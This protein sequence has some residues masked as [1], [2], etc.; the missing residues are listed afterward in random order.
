SRQAVAPRVGTFVSARLVGRWAVP[1][2]AV[3]L[4]ILANT[5]AA[6]THLKRG[7]EAP[8]FALKDRDGADITTT[9]L[10]DHVVVLIFGEV[11]HEKTQQAW[12]AIRTVLDDDRLKD[13]GI[14]PVVITAQAGQ[15]E[16][17]KAFTGG[18]VT[19]RMARDPERQAFEAYRVVAMPSVVVIDREG[20]VVYAVAGLVPRYAD[21]VADSLMYACGKLSA[22]ALERSLHPVPTTQAS[23]TDIRADRLAHLAFQLDRRGLPDMAAE[24]YREA[25]GLNPDHT[26]AHMG[27][28][29]LLLKTRRLAEAE[30]QFRLVLAKQPDSQQALLGLAFVQTLRGGSELDEAEKSVRGMLARS[31][32]LARAHYLL[33]LISEQR[34]K[35]QDAA[36]SFK[37]ASE[38]LLDRAE[39]E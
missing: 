15:P 1:A 6:V 3:C 20:R 11:Y 7:T 22:D 19:P 29:G 13:Q 36:A 12:A 27:L 32:A 35:P 17:L 21:L 31:P 16:D 24:K 37:K 4:A 14:V 9:K 33:G 5:A 38:L 18:H 34:N 26:S 23:D 28:A 30:A 10:K 2:L 25:L 8:P 39:E